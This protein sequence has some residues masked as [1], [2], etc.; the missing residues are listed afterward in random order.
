M[1]LTSMFRFSITTEEVPSAPELLDSAEA[2]REAPMV[3]WEIPRPPTSVS[4]LVDL[5]V[6]LGVPA[7]A[8]LGRH[9]THRSGAA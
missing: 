1:S 9:R 4:V 3:Q 8:C 2:R 6:D 7:A 5:G